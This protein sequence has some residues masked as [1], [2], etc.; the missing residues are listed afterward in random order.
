MIDEV[1]TL[2]GLSRRDF[3]A[4]SSSVGFGESSMK[5]P[6]PAARRAAR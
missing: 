3:E 2:L 6:C 5:T 1:E 4:I